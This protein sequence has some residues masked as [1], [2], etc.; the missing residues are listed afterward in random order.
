MKLKILYTDYSKDE[1]DLDEYMFTGA[2]S[3]VIITKKISREK[4]NQDT[5]PTTVI[6]YANIFKYWTTSKESEE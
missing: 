6:P 1:Y 2:E 4:Y 5:C 3:C